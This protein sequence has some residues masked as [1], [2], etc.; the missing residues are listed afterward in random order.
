[1][2]F[3]RSLK[4]IETML[5]LF[6]FLFNSI[7]PPS[8][9]AAGGSHVRF[10]VAGNTRGSDDGVNAAILAEV[11]AAT[12]SERAN[13]ILVPGNLVEGSDHPDELQSQ[14]ETWRAALD[15]L[16]SAGIAVYP[17]RG[18]HDSGSVDVWNTVFQGPNALPANGPTGEENLSYSFQKGNIFLVGLDAFASPH[19][20]NQ[21]WLDEQLR[22]NQ[23]PHVFVF[24]GES[25]F[26]FQNPA[27]LSQ[28]PAERD[29]FWR[30]LASAGARAYFTGSDDLFAHARID[31]GDGV[32]DNDVHQWIAGT[33]GVVAA[34][35]G[36][37]D[38]DNGAWSPQAVH[39]EA[40]YGYIVIDVNDANVT[41]TWKHRVSA[42]VYRAADEFSYSLD[43]PSTGSFSSTLEG[44]GADGYAPPVLD[45]FIDRTDPEGAVVT[46]P[47]I[48][49][50]PD[51]GDILTYSANGLPAG[52]EINPT[53]GVISGTISYEASAASPYAVEVTV[54]DTLTPVTP[55]SQGFSWTVTD[56]N[57][58]PVLTTPDDQ[59]DAEQDLVNLSILASD[60]DDD[61]LTY[62]ATGLPS[63]L[64]IDQDTGLISGT[65]NYPSSEQ[66]PYS[67]TVTVTDNGLPALGSSAT[68]TWYVNGINYAPILSSIDNQTVSENQTIQLN[69]TATDLNATDTLSFVSPNLP[70][71]ADLT[72]HGDRTATIVLSPT[73]DDAGTY[74]NVVV[75]V[76]DNGGIPLSA[77]QSFNITVN[78]TNQAPIVTNPGAR[79]SAENDTVSLQVTASD[80][81][82]G[83]T[84]SYSAS[85]LPPGLSIHS[86][87]GLISGTVTYD[88]ATELPYA[89]SVSVADDYSPPAVTTVNFSWTVTNRNRSPVVTN[90]GSKF[91]NEG[92]PITL[93]I[94]AN[95]PDAADTLTYSATNLPAG[96]G[97]NSSTGLISGTVAYTAATGSPYSVTV[98]AKDN[99]SPVLSGTEAFEWTVINVNQ[100]P[101]LNNPGEQSSSE[102]QPVVLQI[103]ATDPDVEDTLHYAAIGLPAGLVINPSSGEISGAAVNGAG[104]NS[105]YPVTVTVTDNGISP[106]SASANF[107]WNILTTNHPPTLANPGDQTLLEGETITLTVTALDLDTE[108]TLTLS[109]SG[110]PV[111]AT[112]VDH[113]NR[114][115]TLTISPDYTQ[116][117]TYSDSKIMVTDSA[118][119]QA[120]TSVT[121]TIAVTNAN[122]SPNLADPGS[123][124]VAEGEVLDVSL[125]A[126]DPDTQDTLTFSG[127][128]LPA[129]VSVLTLSN[130][131]GTLHLAPGFDDEGLYPEVVLTATDSSTPS[132]SSS[133]TIT[134][135]VTKTNRPP[136]IVNPGKQTSVEEGPAAL[137]IV[138]SDPDGDLL[139]FSAAGLPTGLVINPTTGAI[140]GTIPDGAAAASPFQTTI[141]VR[142]NGSPILQSNVA[143][144]WEVLAT[145]NPPALEPIVDQNLNEGETIRN[146]PGRHRSRFSGHLDLLSHWTAGVWNLGRSRRSQR[147]HQSC[148]YLPG[149]RPL[150]K[151]NRHGNR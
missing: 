76:T 86:S 77:S 26:S 123:P 62:S 7:V 91:S 5:F 22:S 30:S 125:T 3:R 96:L 97:I 83:D 61:R 117:G 79:G 120:S 149:R 146:R 2:N 90:P 131:S 148:T 138:A 6:V 28:S 98:T 55:V 44:A 11:V 99:G 127:S 107:D 73:F 63:D 147:R 100:M 122:R 14:L 64:S 69:L 40:N 113:H 121:F 67:V 35:D 89:C 93:P 85:N 108:D 36:A 32:A 43:T 31:D 59:T 150:F 20:A 119:P 82:A 103:S 21:A 15:P 130:G 132:L 78:N 126:S 88:A 17:V 95:D 47:T 80:P 116:A 41:I 53:T 84:L 49:S 37:Y 109:A 25:A 42:G 12:I 144:E 8:V 65:F 58:S 52:I 134:I 57:R 87:S 1:M 23:M 74:S 104:V 114:T 39:S 54:Q 33:A 13:F 81:D 38:G 128:N 56:T 136:V 118:A 51:A 137:S 66:S 75:T 27:S 124:T 4:V 133:R 141:T 105:P 10:V 18:S 29:A 106:L 143:F 115:G 92:E 112:F 50:D 139:T 70:L 101:V 94:S 16:S 72:D 111:F 151:Y 60:P 142:D 46:F 102:E 9:S 129:F 140:S 68:F 24:S 19:L 135:T 71:F 34:G 110:L 145:N 48:A 45:P